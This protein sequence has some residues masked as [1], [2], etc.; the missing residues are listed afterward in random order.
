MIVTREDLAT[1]GYCHKG[2]RQL[3]ARL[4]LSWT[5]FVNEG[6]D[7]AELERFDDPMV[8]RLLAAAEART[9]GR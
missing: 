1:L 5:K 3:G 4:G 8:K 2:T 6:I 9:S 7:S